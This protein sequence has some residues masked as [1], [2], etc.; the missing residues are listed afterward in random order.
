VARFL[1]NSRGSIIYEGTRE[2]QK[3]MQAEYAL[4]YRKDK[5][6]RCE[7]PPHTA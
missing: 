5:P 6:P 7:L 2:I 1:R 4:G 3:V